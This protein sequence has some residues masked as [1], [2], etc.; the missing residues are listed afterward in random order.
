MA[1]GT[2]QASIN[3][4]IS[5][6]SLAGYLLSQTPVAEQLRQKRNISA[7]EKSLSKAESAIKD[8]QMSPQERA[9]RSLDIAERKAVV[10]ADKWDIDPSKKT[11]EELQTAEFNVESTAKSIEDIAA[12][13]TVMAEPEDI[14]RERAEQAD[15]EARRADTEKDIEAMIPQ[16]RTYKSR[17][18]LAQE[19]AE[20]KASIALAQ[21]QKTKTKRRN[22]MDYLSKAET[23]YG[24]AMD[25]L[26]EKHL[27]ESAKM[28]SKSER[29]AIMNRMDK[30]GKF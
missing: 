11:L 24:L 22:F 25:V 8:T 4:I 30:G 29:Q 21:A 13:N 9:A 2:I 5:S 16:Y 14:A 27:K 18:E 7:K 12:Q 19:D 3:S 15:I 10:A 17:E 23:Q 26:P 1:A 20:R 28:Y 6:T